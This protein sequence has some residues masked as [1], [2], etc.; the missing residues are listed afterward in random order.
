M[1]DSLLSW[2]LSLDLSHLVPSKKSK[3]HAKHKETHPIYGRESAARL[4]AAD[5]IVR[6]GYSRSDVELVRTVQNACESFCRKARNHGEHW[7][8]ASY[9]VYPIVDGQEEKKLAVD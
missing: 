3:N 5:S 1:D 6:L 7:L 8:A 9:K 2:R 4:D